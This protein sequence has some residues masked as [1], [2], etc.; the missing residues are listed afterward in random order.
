MCTCTVIQ[1]HMNDFQPIQSNSHAMDVCVIG[2]LLVDFLPETRGPLSAVHGFEVHS[3]GAPANVAIGVAQ[4]GGRAC[5][6]S[7]I[8]ADA[9]G[10]FALG[11]LQAEGVDCTR[12]VALPT[13]QTGLCFISLDADGERSFTHRGG[14][15]FGGLTVADLDMDVIGTAKAISFSCGALRSEQSYEAVKAAAAVCKGLVCCDPGGFPDA[16]GDRKEISHRIRLVAGDCDVFKCSAEE[17][18][19]Y[20]DITTPREAV[21]HIHK[22]GCRL[23][24]VTAG[25][26]GAYFA[27]DMGSGH[28]RPPQ[29]N[30][31]DTTGA[32]DAFMAGLI[33]R[34]TATLSGL[35][36]MDLETL[37]S[38]IQ[39]ACQTGAAAIT[40]LGAVKGLGLFAAKR[41]QPG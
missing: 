21:L 37:Q 15:P 4:L 9:F 1:D 22:M 14:D 19:A 3:G 10:Q 6:I 41:T 5:L 27:S 16:W 24:V 17:A 25:D 13:T 35:A 32:G 38:H 30:V 34:L 12:V 40:Q 8:G 7:R 28:T 36:S 33:Y 39:F 29:V 23:A 2:E 11:R 18:K 20:F 26:D 31:V